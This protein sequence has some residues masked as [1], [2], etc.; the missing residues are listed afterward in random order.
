MDV[1]NVSEDDFIK[2]IQAFL[3]TVEGLKADPYV[4]SEGYPSIGIG[5]NL[6]DPVYA[7]E[8]LR[9]KGIDQASPLGAGLL[10]A[11]SKKYAKNGTSALQAA[12]AKIPG[13]KSTNIALDSDQIVQL[14][15]SIA[16]GTAVEGGDATTRNFNGEISHY[17]KFA[18]LLKDNLRSLD[19][20][21][22]REGLAL[23][24]MEFN[25]GTK[26]FGEGLLGALN[27]GDSGRARAWYEIVFNSNLSRNEAD[28]PGVAKRRYEEGAIF[29]LYDPV[30][31][32]LGRV[33][34]S[35]ALNIY[36][37][38]SGD[39]GKGRTLFQNALSND[40]KFSG[41]IA[42]A[43][44]DLASA[45]LDGTV[46]DNIV[47]TGLAG[48][49]M[50]AA[51]SL[52]NHYIV[53]SATAIFLGHGAFDTT[54]FTPFDIQVAD[55]KGGK[56]ISPLSLP[57]QNPQTQ[58]LL[59]AQEGNVT[60]D[61]TGS[62][63]LS[64][65][66]GLP[67]ETNYALIGGSG[68]NSIY[69]GDGNDYVVA[70]TGNTIITGGGGDHPIGSG[71]DTIVLGGAD[72]MGAGGRHT[73]WGGAGDDT[74][75]L[76]L[77]NSD[78]IH[79]GA[80]TSSVNLVDDKN[81]T[82]ATP[83]SVSATSL[84]PLL[85]TRGK[86][87]TYLDKTSNQLLF[88]SKAADNTT[89]LRILG[90]NSFVIE[91]LATNLRLEAAT[92]APPWND[93]V[94]G[95]VALFAGAGAVVDTLDTE[96]IRSLF[97]NY[98]PSD[99]SASNG[100]GILEI[101]GY[102][103]SNLEGV[104]LDDA[105]QAPTGSDNLSQLR[106]ESAASSGYTNYYNDALG[107]TFASIFG[108]DA[109]PGTGYTISGS[110]NA[111]YIKT[112]K[113]SINAFLG[114]LH[115]AAANPLDIDVQGT[116]QGNSGTQ[117]LIGV[118]NGHETIIGGSSGEDTSAWTN[119]DSGGADALLVGGGQNSVIWGGTGHD[120]IVASSVDSTTDQSYN[121]V[122]LA[123]AGLT[124]Y[125][126]QWYSP[127]LSLTAYTDLPSFSVAAISDPADFQ[128]QIQVFQSD[129]TYSAPI[130]LLGSTYVPSSVDSDS[131][132]PGSVMIGGSGFDM[133]IGNS[134]NDTITGGDPVA[135]QG[136]V[137]DEIL[138][139]GAGSDLIYGGS[140]TEVI[141]A[142]MSP[143]A[144]GNWADLDTGHAD[145][146]Y[147]G[148]GNA[149]I[150][151]SGADNVIHGG[152]GNYTIYVGN[153]NSYVETGDGNTIVYGG[154]GNNFIV[155]GSGFDSIEAGD[156]DTYV[157]GGD[158]QS[159]IF[160]GAGDDT[161][162]AGA[163]TTA[164]WAGSGRET[165][166]L[167]SSGG[168]QQLIN[169]SLATAVD[170]RFTPDIDPADI[171]ARRDDGGN[172]QLINLVTG[173]T[174][175]V[176]GYFN[177][178]SGPG[179][180]TVTFSGGTVW[181]ATAIL[182]NTMKASTGDDDL[183]GTDGDDI[184]VGGLGNDTIRGISG[185]DILTGG[186]GN[187]TIYGGTGNSTIIGGDGTN[188]LYG[189]DGNS[190][191]VGGAGPNYMEGASGSS[192]Y[193]FELG[194]GSE[195]ISP[196]RFT[197]GVDVVQFGD[198]IDQ[199]SVK[200][201]STHN[202][203]DLSI[204]FGT[205]SPSTVIITGFFSQTSGSG[206]QVQSFQFS[207]GGA[208]T[209]AQ[210]TA[211]AASN[212]ASDN[213]NDNIH[214]GSGDSQING[215]SGSDTLTGG[216]GNAT[217]IGGS[218]N[219]VITGGTGLNV[220]IGG[221]GYDT[222]TAG[223]NGDSIDAGSGIAEVVG[224][225]GNDTMSSH[226]ALASIAASD[227][228]DTYEFGVGSG[229]LSLSN[230]SNFNI[231]GKGGSDTI[232]IAAGLSS[233]DLTF[234]RV[235]DSYF[236]NNA[237]VIGIKGTNDYFKI[238]D[239]FLNQYEIDP[240]QLPLQIRFANGDVMSYEDVDAAATASSQ[241]NGA[242]SDIV[243]EVPGVDPYAADYFDR[244]DGSKV[245]NYRY[246][247]SPESVEQG[248]TWEVRFGQGVRQQDI[249]LTARGT[250]VIL[251]IRGTGD[252][253]L[254]PGILN[255]A[256]EGYA[257]TQLAFAD[258][259]AWDVQQIVDHT[260]RG[261]GVVSTTDLA[262]GQSI[263][264]GYGDGQKIVNVS[265]SSGNTLVFAPG[266]R[267][268]DIAAVRV[269]HG[270]EFILKSTGETITLV[271]ESGGS[272]VSDDGNGHEDPNFASYPVQQIKF[273]DGAVWETRNI[274][275]F[276]EAGTSVEELESHTPRAPAGVD[277][278]TTG[279]ED[280]QVFVGSGESL[281]LI[282]D[283]YSDTQAAAVIHVG[284]DFG[285]TTIEGS[286]D[287][288]GEYDLGDN[289]TVHFDGVGIADLSISRT[290]DDR[291]VDGDSARGFFSDGQGYGNLTLTSRSTGH[292]IVVP[293]RIDT[294]DGIS[295]TSSI[296]GISFADGSSL[297]I[298]SLIGAAT[299]VTTGVEG[300]RG[301]HTLQ[302]ADGQE[303]RAAIGNTVLVGS[304][305][306][307]E[308]DVSDVDPSQVPT[309]LYVMSSDSTADTIIANIYSTLT[310]GFDA[311]SANY[312][313]I[314]GLDGNDILYRKDNG[315]FVSLSVEGRYISDPAGGRTSLD[316][317]IAFSD[318]T[319]QGKLQYDAALAQSAPLEITDTQGRRGYYIDSINTMGFRFAY[320]RGSVSNQVF[321]GLA[322]SGFDASAADVVYDL[323]G[324]HKQIDAASNAAPVNFTFATGL[325]DA[326][327]FNF[328]SGRFNIDFAAGISAADVSVVE[329]NGDVR[330][331]VTSANG[332]QDMLEVDNLYAYSPDIQSFY[333]KQITL[334]FA[335]GT[336]WTN[337]DVHTRAYGLDNNRG[338]MS[339]EVWIVGSHPGVVD[340]SGQDSDTY[341][342]VIIKSDVGN[343]LELGTDFV[344]AN[345]GQT[346]FLVSRRSQAKI[347]GFDSSKDEIGIVDGLT[348]SDVGVERS[349]EWDSKNGRYLDAIVLVD[350]QTGR[351]LITVS[352]SRLF[353]DDTPVVSFA[354]GKSWSFAE[355]A[356]SV[357]FSMDAGAVGYYVRGADGEAN[358][359]GSSGNDVIAA[360]AGAVTIDGAGGADVLYA[361]AGDDTFMFGAGYG[362]A[363]IVGMP[364]G[365][366]D[367]VLSLGAGI[368]T[369]DVEVARADDGSNV[370]LR[371]KDS[372]DRILL[373]NFF[374]PSGDQAIQSL[375]FADGSSWSAADILS[376]S[377]Q[378]GA[379]SK[380]IA[381]D[382][383]HEAIAGGNG[384][385]TIVGD[386]AQDTLAGGAGQNVIRSGG[387]NNRI[388]LG[389]G[390]D[391]VYGGDGTDVI[392]MGTGS[393]TVY[394]GAGAEAFVFGAS[395]GSSTVYA[396]DNAVANDIQFTDGVVAQDVSF[397]M[398]RDGSLHVSLD[399]GHGSIVLPGHIVGSTEET[400]VDRV[401]FSD[402][403][404]ASMASID[405]LLATSGGNP[406][407]ASPDILDAGLPAAYDP[408]NSIHIAGAPQVAP[409]RASHLVGAVTTSSEQE[410]S[411]PAWH[412]VTSGL[413]K[414]A[415]KPDRSAAVSTRPSLG[416][417][418]LSMPSASASDAGGAGSSFN[419]HAQGGPGG[420]EPDHDPVRQHRVGLHGS[421]ASV[422]SEARPA[423]DGDP[424]IRI[425]GRLGSTPVRPGAPRDRIAEQTTSAAV[426]EDLAG[427]N[428]IAPSATSEKTAGVGMSRHRR[429]VARTSDAAEAMV[430]A[431]SAQ[432]SQ[433][434]GM[435]RNVKDID[436]R[437]DLTMAL[438][439]SHGGEAQGSSHGAIAAGHERMIQAMASFA[440][441][442]AVSSASLSALS[443]A[444][445]I[446]LAV[447]AH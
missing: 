64:G 333:E 380:Y 373:A 212:Y 139:G 407:H 339:S 224:G 217:I 397:A 195:T 260:D 361:G 428:L 151:G 73:V 256:V 3:T 435:E 220:L 105:P 211:L 340:L 156:G 70:G 177:S 255:A 17:G 314:Q 149:Y 360:G 317:T 278:I 328:D 196:D 150:Y 148:S 182:A 154:S 173:R 262:D 374:D 40:A 138:V 372:G 31:V 350:R 442:P 300:T 137:V 237:L 131:T 381:A 167:G 243:P 6:H 387:G 375:H 366:H 33:P 353:L 303:I 229:Q 204:T 323:R 9:I 52:V 215:G 121:P 35:E 161:F 444:D 85:S 310:F 433:T 307:V 10:A 304:H 234:T 306:R 226:G 104:T 357:P 341:T 102:D 298:S 134:G 193:V 236:G 445:A 130:E 343:T 286:Y 63:F 197:S 219:E 135:P 431:L 81:S 252:T 91:P 274:Y 160:A 186:S 349:S 302:A 119:I 205:L 272:D 258:G 60:L 241:W 320:V 332:R 153:G 344:D 74:Y 78:V 324:L 19:L 99:S 44:A 166:L 32:T 141:F 65:V 261:P 318:K 92:E 409:S 53:D 170:I 228:V 297:D 345:Q 155:A 82:I 223:N 419:G 413:G 246:N 249:S 62:G 250:D 417:G 430:K 235:G 59:V 264:F 54:A 29:G 338:V 174:L 37:T 109:A 232:Q 273:A 45:V 230:E 227:G 342:N 77:K 39:D 296:T 365:A 48:G 79:L 123:V 67:G 368:A 335:D 57:N 26:L 287:R 269:A 16:I 146:I 336:T 42:A 251:T 294:S 201:A 140:G 330:F 51:Q 24:S 289:R 291:S 313:I 376:R 147:G 238:D 440:V 414:P 89:T 168:D 15:K 391:T 221:S 382:A 231:E 420:D 334:H 76:S 185:N 14:F 206:H 437:A 316:L 12:I 266:I 233:A 61:G 169:A 385:D 2:A 239:Y 392:V 175:R 183:W 290:F 322:W 171:V 87:A 25:A 315:N 4:D 179:T 108:N 187:N 143:G 5:I 157:Y 93:L 309:S 412:D 319:L 396:A 11:F 20:L 331:V 434:G 422:P 165:L 120:T 363:T 282:G 257:A 429:A 47:A 208:L 389:E 400:D 114:D 285:N 192:T 90:L 27:Q 371:L 30:D 441:Q 94:D 359:T 128:V 386:E 136:G 301:D 218:G 293:Y 405:A 66:P 421:V 101:D 122:T 321:D 305:Q 69:V 242:V 410:P 369:D 1:T 21:N 276:I 159:T 124:F 184:I 384:N 172:L 142:D 398:A 416:A 200:F 88:S 388:E 97:D 181:D 423:H 403:S 202:G 404:A 427:N 362:Q 23:Q 106:S 152:S 426:G 116:I 425:H 367:N 281:V 207:N 356:R 268:T 399:N 299:V 190:T 96:S 84:S 244:G 188:Y 83:I 352:G 222:I 49:L 408:A 355:L 163:G 95:I 292:Q 115:Y 68:N 198:G 86:T 270:V 245:L 364:G 191:L 402:G 347:V 126:K 424:G 329:D 103:G 111:T 98:A 38:L 22:T 213:G 180:I 210:V 240:E 383:S 401:Y 144:V 327:V 265:D 379:T 28:G 107:A 113:G 406:V 176:D 58:Q 127:P 275:S 203:A 390:S 178:G 354:D 133:L 189:G 254:I 199:N 43:N 439:G 41:K 393:A 117:D 162:E 395:F 225:M 271:D 13:A 394:G 71:D 164:Y 438:L 56:T 295:I 447:H 110:G 377:Y 46:L 311:Q 253:L 351:R 55:K 80:G 415:A 370:E 158:G 118:G 7:K 34:V 112:G 312:S 280:N 283:G 100:T 288:D 145:T 337:A 259:S 267:S 411:D 279:M 443:E 378:G 194:N 50:P 214:G 36:G 358:L 432:R 18:R 209:A 348:A 8:Y 325:G 418:Q 125:G 247:L 75:Y 308:A 346:T 263:T 216:S 436:A 326:R 132:L 248:G 72:G 277:V 129:G 284:P 446:T